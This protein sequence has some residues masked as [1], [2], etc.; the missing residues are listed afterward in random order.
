MVKAMR[1]RAVL[2]WFGVLLGSFVASPASATLSEALSLSDLVERSQ[3]V[4]VV[5]C[6][7]ERTV[8]DSRGRIVTDYGLTIQESWRGDGAP[9]ETITMRS[10]GG[11]LGDIGMRVEGEPR[12]GVGARYL[13]FLRRLS[14]GGALRPVGMSQGVMPVETEGAT[15]RV[16]PGG[17]GLALRQRTRG[18]RLIEAPPAI[19]HPEPL[20]A[21]RERVTALGGG[22]GVR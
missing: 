2:P 7:D 9:G 15:V 19:V 12:L 16:L 1:F 5:T 6:T 13:V 4:A 10:L 18:G 8:R 17:E 3:L 22:E 21:V 14:G 20:E 11:V